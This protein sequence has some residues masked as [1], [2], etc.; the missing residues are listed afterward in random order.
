MG[1]LLK[2][3]LCSSEELKEVLEKVDLPLQRHR[4]GG[5]EPRIAS[6]P[7]GKPRRKSPEVIGKNAGLEAW[8]FL[9]CWNLNL[10]GR[11]RRASGATAPAL[12]RSTI[13]CKKR[14]ASSTTLAQQKAVEQLRS[15][16]VDFMEGPPVPKPGKFAR[17]G[18]AGRQRP[19]DQTSQSWNVGAEPTLPPCSLRQ[20]MVRGMLKEFLSDPRRCVVP[21]E[22][23][24]QKV[25]KA[26]VWVEK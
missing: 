8:M 14:L 6:F 22:E 12:D 11:R 7:C 26:N 3:H 4:S 20:D 2:N 15:N 9:R 10:Y 21:V 18:Q 25:P 24:P 16:V 5:S 23:W 19:R 17:P 1:L 13:D